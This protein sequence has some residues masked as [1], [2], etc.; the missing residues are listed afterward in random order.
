MKASKSSKTA[1]QMALSRAIESRRP[2]AERICFDPWAERFLDPAYRMLLVGRPLRAGVVKLID[3]LFPGH[4]GYVLVRTR[5]IDELLGQALTE[6]AQ[7]V[8]LL[9]AG[10]DSRPYRFADRLAGAAVFEVDHPATSAMKR[11]KVQRL[12]GAAPDHVTYVP[13]DFDRDALDASL[14]RSGYRRDRQTTFIW[15]GT[16]P[17]LSAEGVD[18][19]LRFIATKG[20]PGS[21]VVFDY[22]LASVLDASSAS[23]DARREYE[24]MKRT[25]EPFVFGI[26]PE[27]IE[28]FLSERGYS[29]VVDVGSEELSA[30]FVRPTGRAVTIKPW[31]R[32][33]HAKLV[34]GF[35][36]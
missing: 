22:I 14:E 25:D 13:V 2:E 26:A 8:V 18:A 29:H 5:Y 30:R 31:W 12:L 23:P 36:S 1:A 17:Y 9:G 33:A 11:A 3:A 6:G 4:H 28:T 19:T 24:K 16:T 10:F 20:A 15:E 35:D 34:N 7:Q 32:I 21:T 27:H